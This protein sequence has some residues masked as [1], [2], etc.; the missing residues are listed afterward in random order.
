M[1]ILLMGKS[2]YA[3]MAA[4]TALVVNALPATMDSYSTPMSQNAKDV[5]RTVIA[6]V[7][8]IEISVKHAVLELT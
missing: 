4:R 1:A 5:V 8:V 6:A 3:S 7:L 2:S